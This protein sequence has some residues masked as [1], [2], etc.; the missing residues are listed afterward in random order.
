ML[1]IKLS[2]SDEMANDINHWWSG[3]I[4][5]A[6]RVFKENYYSILALYVLLFVS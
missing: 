6:Q 1:L 2:L 5:Y 3:H 4:L